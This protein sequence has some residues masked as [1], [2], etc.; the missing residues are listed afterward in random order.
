MSFFINNGIVEVIDI[1]PSSQI[2]HIFIHPKEK[3]QSGNE[4]SYVTKQM[5]IAGKYLGNEG[6]LSF[7]HW[8]FNSKIINTNNI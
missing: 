1:Q 7:G 2:V 5:E 6:F 8:T 4:S 3:L